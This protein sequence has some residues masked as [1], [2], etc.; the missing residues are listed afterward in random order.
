MRYAALEG[1]GL[2]SQADLEMLARV[3]TAQAK[4][5][6][7]GL[8]DATK[9]T[10][11]TI[12]KDL[13]EPVADVEA[14]LGKMGASSVAL[15]GVLAGVLLVGLNNTIYAVRQAAG[16]I[17]DFVRDSIA[18]A[19]SFNTAWTN[20]LSRFENAWG[21]FQKQIGDFFVLS[22]SLNAAISSIASS[23]EQWTLNLSDSSDK[24]L[25]YILLL[26]EMGLVLVSIG[27]TLVNNARAAAQFWAL[28]PGAAGD[29]GADSV[30]ALDD[31]AGGL[32][33]IREALI[34]AGAAA[35][36]VFLA[37]GGALNF[38][39]YGPD[40]SFA[41]GSGGG[42]AGKKGSAIGG[43]GPGSGMG[44]FGIDPVGF[45]TA[46]EA[47][48]AS[49]LSVSEVIAP[50]S[51]QFT[52]MNQ[53]LKEMA[54]N[55]GSSSQMFFDFVP[56]LEQSSISMSIANSVT[57][58]MISAFEQLVLTGNFSARSFV[59]AVG[60][61]VAGVLGKMA[62]EA[63]ARAQMEL[64][65]AVASTAVG[66]YRGSALHTAA[67]GL[68]L[69]TARAAGVGAAVAGGAALY[70]GLSDGSDS[71]SGGGG[72]RGRRRDTTPTGQTAAP[73]SMQQNVTI[74]LDG[75]GFIQDPTAFAQTLQD[76]LD[77][78]NKRR[79]RG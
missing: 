60:L 74:Y 62:I 25:P 71:G 63:Y 39:Q 23:F 10:G 46:G 56:A 28:M 36:N 17:A 26:Q 49:V 77:R 73:A 8:E 32:G 53:Q 19:G 24:M 64:A 48:R 9:K 70:A 33:R 51:T 12:D 18:L 11:S 67:A 78:V 79:G 2:L 72:G 14:G 1:L 40:S 27:E 29:I 22:P 20:T 4:R 54:E 43:I 31:I 75:Q 41:G 55:V 50:L 61:Q 37:N 21:G 76:S 58:Q 65:L 57:D 68:F 59:K 3:E 52:L 35:A 34:Q 5:D 44:F 42:D 13:G 45:Q 16:A 15:A 6:L 7:K 69:N 47:I 30:K 66:D 38:A